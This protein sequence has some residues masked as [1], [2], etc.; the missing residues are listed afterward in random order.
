[1]KLLICLMAL[2]VTGCSSYSSVPFDIVKE[3][4]DI[5]NLS[6]AERCE[7]IHV[8]LRKSCRIKQKEEVKNLSKAMSKEH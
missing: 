6:P 7:H 2:L 3:Q 4:Y 8:D 1:M 5:S